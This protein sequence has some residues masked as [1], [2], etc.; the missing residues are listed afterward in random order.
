[1]GPHQLPKSNFFPKSNLGRPEWVTPRWFQHG[2]EYSND[3]QC[4]RQTSPWPCTLCV[5]IRPSD[6]G[7]RVMQHFS[8]WEDGLLGAIHTV[9][10]RW[11]LQVLWCLWQRPHG[12]Q[13]WK[14]LTCHLWCQPA[15][16]AS[17]EWESSA[18]ECWHGVVSRWYRSRTTDNQPCWKDGKF[19]WQPVWG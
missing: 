3:W 6:S 15:S 1:M 8:I 10:E 7:V 12:V 14:V 2:T 9:S 19:K 17:G 5:E 11:L 16:L 18:S 13:S 4:W